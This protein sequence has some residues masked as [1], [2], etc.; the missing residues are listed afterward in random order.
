VCTLLA[1]QLKRVRAALPASGDDEPV[2]EELARFGVAINQS[3]A[4]LSRAG[5]SPL[6]L[7][8]IV[9]TACAAVADA[10]ARFAVAERRGPA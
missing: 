3:L 9:R 5:A 2:L 8:S 6:E 1:L 7:R 10:L 4:V